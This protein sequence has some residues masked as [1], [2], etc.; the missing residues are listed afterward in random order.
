[1]YRTLAAAQIS[2][3]LIGG[4]DRDDPE[5]FFQ[6]D[7]VLLEAPNWSRD[8]GAL[9]V[10]GDG[11]LW[12]IEVDE[13]SSGPSQI[14][15]S[16]LPPINNDHVLDPDGEHI[17][18]STDDGHIYRGALSGGEVERVTPVDGRWHFLHG[19]SPDGSRLAYVD[20]GAFADPGRLMVM[21]ASGGSPTLVPTGTGH[22]DGPEWTPDG[23]WILF[24]TESFSVAPGH[25]QLARIAEGGETPERLVISSTV[26]WFPHPSPDGCWA[27]YISFPSG[28]LGH[29]AD[30]EVVV[31]VVSTDEWSTPVQSYR[32]FGGQGTIN[33]SSWAPDSSRFAFIVYP[34]V[35][36]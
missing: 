6:T 16:N 12:R 2:Q 5:V 24:N 33:V 8:G 35:G 22:L 18:M 13:P 30:L 29:P 19:I 20:I 4:A 15:F 17:Y 36:R 9:Y 34:S 3:I 14:P 23:R 11:H 32:V 26:D 21:P 1:M 25:A 27:S 28:T 7:R 31:H 10:N